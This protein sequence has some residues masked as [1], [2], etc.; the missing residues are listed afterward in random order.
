M[1][2]KNKLLKVKISVRKTKLKKKMK[3]LSTQVHAL[4]EGK[5]KIKD[6]LNS[7]LQQ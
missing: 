1:M 5:S 7:S 4:D 6:A 3:S 2:P